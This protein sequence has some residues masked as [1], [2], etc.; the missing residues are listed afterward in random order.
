MEQ[1]QEQIPEQV[2]EQVEQLPTE[3]TETQEEEAP[4]KAPTKSVKTFWE[5][6]DEVFNLTVQ[7][8]K[9][10]EMFEEILSQ[11]PE[12]AGLTKQQRSALFQPER[13]LLSS[14]DDIQPPTAQGN[15]NLIVTGD[16]FWIPSQ[17]FNSFR[18]RLKRP[19][20]NVK[21][22]QLLSAGIP[23]ATQNIPDTQLFFLY[24]RLR[25]VA[26]AIQGAYVPATTYQAGDIVTYL[27]NTFASLQNANTNNTPSGANLG[28]FWAGTSLPA[29]TTRPNYFDMAAD[30]I[31]YVSLSPS[32]TVPN[33]PAPQLINRTFQDYNDLVTELQAAA[34]TANAS[35]IPG[36]VTFAYDATLNKI[37][38]EP[39]NTANYYYLP[40]GFEDP[41][42]V[43]FYSDLVDYLRPPAGYT[44]NLRLGFTWNGI[45]TSPS[46]QNPWTTKG[47]STTVWPY[48]RPIDPAYGPPISPI[49][50]PDTLYANNYGDLVNTSCIRIYT[51]IT[52]GSTQD[53]NNT[54]F[55]DAEGLLSVI[56]VNASNLGVGFYQNNFSN[57][58]TKIPQTITE[59]GIRLV[60]DQGL[61]FLLPNSATVLLELAVDY[62]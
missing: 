19:L 33:G 2:Q 6:L 53:T 23:N 32:W 16:P 9:Q 54:S 57:P 43:S 48:L 35:S 60:N 56:P 61:P 59:I 12:V 34:A 29:D 41:N 50:N 31:Q 52:L 42:V 15:F 49:W 24:Y 1:D 28:V 45:F 5:R 58:L 11:F 17:F 51:D 30:A 55:Q 8:A 38:F 21:S 18:V 46:Q 13:L 44:M 20:I 27:G 22:L 37:V 36:D 25:R 3:L 7:G 10:R 40:V 14:N 26:A 4:A 39:Q 47:A 62:F